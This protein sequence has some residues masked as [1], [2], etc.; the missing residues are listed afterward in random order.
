MGK[1]WC[2]VEIRIN[3]TALVFLLSAKSKQVSCCVMKISGHQIFGKRLNQK[4]NPN[5]LPT[6]NNLSIPKEHF[7]FRL[8]LFLW[9]LLCCFLLLLS[10]SLSLLKRMRQTSPLSRKILQFYFLSF[11]VNAP[12]SLF[13]IL[14]ISS[15]RWIDHFDWFCFPISLVTLVRYHMRYALRTALGVVNQ[16]GVK[17][18]N[19]LTVNSQPSP[20]ASI[21]H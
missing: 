3:W 7:G 11:P 6:I 1:N 10:L 20:L 15:T 5:W 16:A 17:H 13:L 12:Q 9:L 8:L 4:E 14:F 19:R 21:S 18:K 2:G